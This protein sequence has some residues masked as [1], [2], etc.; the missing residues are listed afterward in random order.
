MT[1][2]IAEATTL[3]IDFAQ[4]PNAPYLSLRRR[5]DAIVTATLRQVDDGS[6]AWTRRP[7]DAV[8][9]EV[10][11]DDSR[12][13][14]TGDR[15]VALTLPAGEPENP[16]DYEFQAAL[17]VDDTRLVWPTVPRRVEFVDAVV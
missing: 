1:R 16:G 3:S 9:L 17:S 13:K 5:D 10:T 15:E 6:V 4:H 7:P 11:L 12:L 14:I 2:S 8:S